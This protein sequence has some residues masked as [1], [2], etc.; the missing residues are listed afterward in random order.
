MLQDLP[1]IPVIFNCASDERP[2]FLICILFAHRRGVERRKC[3]DKK[4]PESR[5]L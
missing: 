3:S 2:G 5:K 1:R 4:M